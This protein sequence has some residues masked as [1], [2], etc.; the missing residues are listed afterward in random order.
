MT[1]P[2]I[3]LEHEVKWSLDAAQATRDV[4]RYLNAAAFG[5]RLE[6]ISATSVVTQSAV[7]LDDAALSLTRAGHALT[8][9]VNTGAARDVTWFR[10]KHSIRRGGRHDTL[11]IAQRVTEPVSALLSDRSNPVIGHALTCHLFDGPLSVTG[12][13]TQLR[14]KRHGIFR[15]ST[16]GLGYGVDIVEFK[17]P[18][19][20]AVLGTYAC[21]EIEINESTPD[22][23]S[24]LDDL[25]AALDGELGADR[26]REGKAQLAVRAAGPGRS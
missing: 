1:E 22:G 19:S 10:L 3:G 16:C 23:L 6:Q 18:A 4:D 9:V 13:F 12:V 5:R 14:H 7:V 21:L 11:E 26:E 2:F 15:D 20:G 25:A 17:A 8:A 24:L